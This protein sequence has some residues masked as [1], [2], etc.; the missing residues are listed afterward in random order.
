[1]LVWAA[2]VS[3][4]LIL[5]DIPCEL[6]KGRVAVSSTLEVPGAPGVW[7]VGD[8]ALISDPT[9]KLPYP[10]TA[11]HALREGRRAGENIY[12]RLQG[13]EL[14]LFRYKMLGQLA[15][16]GR[17]TGVAK[18]FGLKFSG[19][20]GWLL[21]R[22]VYLMKLPRFEKKLRVGLQWALDVSLRAT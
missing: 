13:K 15:T 4:S 18:M 22:T 20:L 5:N 6:Q 21:W 3:P 12:A 14:K 10:P 17:R 1:M 2:G 8:C 19:A 16:I 9:S 7:A 11:Q